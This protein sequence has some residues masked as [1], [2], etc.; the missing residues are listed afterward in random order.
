MIE[1][2]KEPFL[3]KLREIELIKGDLQLMFRL[4][5]GL[6]D[7][8]KIKNNSRLSTLNFASRKYYSIKSALLERR[9]PCDASKCNNKSTV[10]LLSD[11][12]SC[13]DHQMPAIEG[14]VEEAIGSN[15]QAIKL[16]P[17]VVSN[18]RHFV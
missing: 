3:D 4:H 17:E 12:E 15:R 16:I 8:K 6:R 14:I 11:L 10:Y 9:L 2:G 7:D 1:K 18:F 5:V 13:Y